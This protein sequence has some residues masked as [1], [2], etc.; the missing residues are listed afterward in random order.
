MDLQMDSGVVIVVVVA[1]VA[2]AVG[3]AFAAESTIPVV[4]PG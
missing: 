3:Q 2:V 4:D 1:A